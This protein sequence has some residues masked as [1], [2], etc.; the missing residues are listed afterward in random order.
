MP[1]RGTR[2]LLKQRIANG[3]TAL[4]KARV[5]PGCFHRKA[6]V[7]AVMIVVAALFCSAS[8]RRTLRSGT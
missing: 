3:K 5:I 6:T 4:Q 1:R 7:A 8:N 2:P